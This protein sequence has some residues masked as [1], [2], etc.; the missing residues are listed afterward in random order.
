MSLREW[1]II[2]EPYTYGAGDPN[3]AWSAWAQVRD[4]ATDP[5]RNCGD[6]Q[7]GRDHYQAHM[8]ARA[9]AH[10][11]A[12]ADRVRAEGRYVVEYGERP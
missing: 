5:W 9:W 1:R 10:E 12:E 4:S 11:V 7:F 6:T 8:A 2:T 3:K